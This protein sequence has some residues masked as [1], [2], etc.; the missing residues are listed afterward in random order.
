MEDNTNVILGSVLRTWAAKIQPPNQ[1][2][3]KLL[4]RA[5]H[6]ALKRKKNASMVIYTQ[7]YRPADWSHMLLSWD[8][9]FS[10]PGGLN[11]SRLLI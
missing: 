6:P 9:N 11:S 3:A 8:I 7:V 5:A 10:F 1:S 2:R 4:W